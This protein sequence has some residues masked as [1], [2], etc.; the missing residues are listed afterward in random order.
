MCKGYIRANPP[1]RTTQRVTIRFWLSSSK[2]SPSKDKGAARTR[3]RNR[4]IQRSY[5]CVTVIK[6]KDV[7]T[8]F[9]VKVRFR[10]MLIQCK[11]FS[12]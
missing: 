8:Y 7:C 2:T 11:F 10:K 5:K 3:K 4:T 1:G 9:R 6:D 12:Y